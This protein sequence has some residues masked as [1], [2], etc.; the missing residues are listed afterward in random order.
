MN[1]NMNA[2]MGMDVTDED[3]VKEYGVPQELAGTPAI[4]DWMIEDTRVKN[5]NYYLDEG[6]SE[7]EANKLAN[8]NADVAKKRLKDLMASKGLL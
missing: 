1:Y 7:K 5:I 6:M 4:N 8:G 2:L 3:Y